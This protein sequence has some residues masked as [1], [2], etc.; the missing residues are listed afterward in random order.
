MG[1]EGETSDA[2]YVGPAV[3]VLVVVVGVRFWI[4]NYYRASSFRAVVVGGRARTRKNA[5]AAIKPRAGAGITC[6]VTR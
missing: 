2:G 3:V 5:D 1:I 6:R 4:E